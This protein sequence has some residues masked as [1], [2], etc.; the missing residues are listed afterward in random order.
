MTFTDRVYDL[1][2]Q[3]PTGYV[4]TYKQLAEMAGSKDAARA[5]GASM[6]NN[7][8]PDVIPCHRVVASNGDLTGYAFGGTTVKK[9]KLL[10]EGVFFK[11][12][13]VDLSLSQWKPV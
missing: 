2:K 5:V 4:V 1:A 8:N 9:A 11:G 13:K 6:R 7:H 10:K 12:N 3:I